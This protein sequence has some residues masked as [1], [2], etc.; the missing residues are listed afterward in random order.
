MGETRNETQQ[1]A[2]SLRV[3]AQRHLAAISTPPSD[4]PCFAKPPKPRFLMSLRAASLPIG[5]GPRVLGRRWGSTIAR[6][7]GVDGVDPSGKSLWTVRLS[8]HQLNAARGFEDWNPNME[9]AKMLRQ[10]S[11]NFLKMSLFH[12]KRNQ[13]TI[14]QVWPRKTSCSSSINL[15]SLIYKHLPQNHY[16]LRPIS[17]CCT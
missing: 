1:L 11:D 4:V 2:D 14:H 5:G 6:L 10:A 8:L 9:D 15:I 3:E 16:T 17:T 7:F 12:S 13:R